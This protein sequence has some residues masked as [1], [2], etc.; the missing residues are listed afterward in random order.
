MR[1]AVGWSSRPAQGG[2][3]NGDAAFVRHVGWCS[4]FGVIDALGHGPE[5]NAAAAAA[6][7]YLRAVK[8]DDG[9]QPLL[10]GLDAR[11]RGTR[12]AVATICLFDR[13]QL[14]IAGVGN[15]ELLVRGVSLPWSS[16]PGILGS[17]PQRPHITGA[18]LPLGARLHLFSN[19]V[20]S[21]I[22]VDEVAELAPAS[23]SAQLLSHY[24]VPDEDA[25][26]L[27]AEVYET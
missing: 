26:L 22:D 19:G 13:G 7:D 16:T 12:G 17:R 9:L 20:S 27:I 24:S 11:L 3:H 2:S 6:V 21:R 18:R 14:S 15:V 10:E 25:T 8:L 23:A 4:L 1:V 5:A